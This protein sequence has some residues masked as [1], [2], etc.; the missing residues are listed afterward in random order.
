MHTSRRVRP[1]Q[2]SRSATGRPSTT[3]LCS[4]GPGIRIGKHAL[5]GTNVEVSDSDFHDLHPTRRRGGVPAKAPVLIGENVFVGS[6]VKILK[7]VTIG[8]DT[9]V[10]NGS[11]VTK[12]LPAGVIAAGSPARVLGSLDDL[13]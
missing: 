2:S 10:G 13:G 12:D 3:V 1:S 11:I 8:A 9:V 6:N 7:G 5:F 4:E